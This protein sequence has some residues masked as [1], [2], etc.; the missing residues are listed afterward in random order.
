MQKTLLQ[1]QV[2]AFEKWR[3]IRWQ[4]ASS[5]RHSLFARRKERRLK[6]KYL[7]LLGLT[8]TEYMQ[9]MVSTDE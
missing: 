6:S 4:L 2:E 7:K 3:A 9:R 8:P 1:Q 5:G